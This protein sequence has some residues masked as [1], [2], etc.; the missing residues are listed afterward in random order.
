M[1]QVQQKLVIFDFDGTLADTGLP[2]SR[3]SARTY[4]KFAEELGLKVPDFEH[5]TA[6]MDHP[7]QA[8]LMTID[9]L[10]VIYQTYGI[11]MRAHQPEISAAL[12]EQ[13][14]TLYAQA[15][16]QPFTGVTDALKNILADGYRLAVA[17]SN[18]QERLMF[19]MEE[20]G[21]AEYFE[22][23]IYG[24]KSVVKK[25]KPAPDVILLVC[26]DNNTKAEDAIYIGDS[27][28]DILASRA[29]GMGVLIH[30]PE[31]DHYFV[32]KRQIFID[33]KVPVFNRFDELPA[34]VRMHLPS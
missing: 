13:K 30:L 21:L 3:I 31:E 20:K 4:M 18:T 10:E 5:L 9:K 29:A 33:E 1:K 22:G 34:L 15:D 8:G 24:S 6:L 28:A 12:G 16:V 17:S 26:A 14:D 27:M 7:D 25:D 32:E 19:G 2:Y 23:G 11:D